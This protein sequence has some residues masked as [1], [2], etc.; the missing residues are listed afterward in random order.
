[1]SKR[2]Y[3]KETAEALGISQWALRGMAKSGEIPCW[4]T[5]NRY[6]FDIQQCEEFLNNKAMENVNSTPVAMYGV[7][8]KCEG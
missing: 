2:A 4:K 1:M 7:L 5:G 3:L 8:R 6:I